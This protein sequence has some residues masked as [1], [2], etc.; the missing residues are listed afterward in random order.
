MKM[1]LE[2]YK[3]VSDGTSEEEKVLKISSK[4]PLDIKELLNKM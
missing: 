3:V 4:L 2:D 1:A